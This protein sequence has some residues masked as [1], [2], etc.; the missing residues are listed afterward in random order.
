MKESQE[1]R[2]ERRKK[3]KKVWNDIRVSKWV[4]YSNVR[5]SFLS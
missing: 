4:K 1:E 2:K 5:S 3:V